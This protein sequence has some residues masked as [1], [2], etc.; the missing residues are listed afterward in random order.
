MSG[1]TQL[2]ISSLLP[3]LPHVKS[4]K[5]RA[6]AVTSTARST[7]VPDIPTAAE[8]GMP[9]F[10]TSSW[11]GILVP[12][13][14]PRAVI[15]RLHDELVRVLN[16][17]DVRERLTAQGLNIVASTPEQF[18]AYLKSETAKYA[19]VIRQAGIKLE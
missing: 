12:E 16:M 18:S 1:E 19:R 2:I 14:T 8:S 6:L 17:P 15:T 5:L 11:H 4:G 3:V 9:A 10:E 13:K 7:A